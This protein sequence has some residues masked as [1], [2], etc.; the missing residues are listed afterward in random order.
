MAAAAQQ[1]LTTFLAFRRDAEDAIKLYTS[2]FDDAEV[3]RI[4]RA[5]ADEPGWLAGTLQHAVFTLAGL[6]FMCI[7]MPPPGARGHDHAAWHEYEFSPAMAIY[8][9]CRDNEEIERLY[10]ALS[11]LGQT[12]MPPGSYGFSEKFAWVT[13]RFGVSWRLNL[14]ADPNVRR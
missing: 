6:Q 9:Q 2:L 12:I 13:D 3:G 1:K 8:V 7:N 14:S 4:I 5:R 10:A 11:D